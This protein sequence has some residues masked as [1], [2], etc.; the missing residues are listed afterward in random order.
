MTAGARAELQWAQRAVQADCQ[1]IECSLLFLLAGDDQVVDAP[2]AR[3]LAEGLTPPARVQ[4]YPTLGHE[5]A[6]EPEGAGRAVFQDMLAF[7]A[8]TH[9]LDAVPRNE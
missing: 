9:S 8:R 3:T 2:L 5:S 6:A 4:W 7:L 1:R